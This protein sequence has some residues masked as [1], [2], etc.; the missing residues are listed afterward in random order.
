[1]GRSVSKGRQKL[2][3]ETKQY[4]RDTLEELFEL[5]EATDPEKGKVSAKGKHANAIK[6]LMKMGYLSSKL[7]EWAE[8]HLI[9]AYYNKKTSDGLLPS[10]AESDKHKNECMWHDEDFYIDFFSNE[11]DL[12]NHREAA[13]KI[14]HYTSG[15]KHY[16]HWRG[17][18]IKTLKALNWGQVH[19][20]AERINT[21][22]HGHAF[23]LLESKI[24]AVK[25]VY[26]FMGEGHRKYSAQE[27]VMEKDYGIKRESLRAW[28]RQL[29]KDGY[30]KQENLNNLKNGAMFLY[31]NK[32]SNNPISEK[33][34][35][36]QAMHS[37]AIHEFLYNMYS[38]DNS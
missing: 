14:L 1:M 12:H 6:A 4:C 20:F 8:Y 2:D 37:I 18:L 36:S 35:E 15:N 34:I 5:Y 9:G 17:P 32:Q 29:K 27:F 26:V 19:G 31:L 11:D 25:Y 38:S 33:E 13:S 28:E 10:S 24:A 22:K 3:E 7:T 30:L 23:D 16:P 21:K